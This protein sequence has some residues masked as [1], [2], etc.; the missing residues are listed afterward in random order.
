MWKPWTR[1]QI[2]QLVADQCA[3]LE[4]HELQ[5]LH[6]VQHP[7]ALVAWKRLAAFGDDGLDDN[8]TWVLARS[9]DQALLFDTVEEEFGIGRIGEDG[10]LHDYGTY[11]EKLVWA[12]RHF[13]AGE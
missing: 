7:A 13:P 9:G 4:D 11:G 8:S 2:E 5:E 1:P 6:R 3:G 10:Q 12:L